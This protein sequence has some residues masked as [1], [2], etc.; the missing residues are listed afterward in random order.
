MH[1]DNRVPEVADCSPQRPN[2]SLEARV[3]GLVSGIP[4]KLIKVDRE[5]LQHVEFVCRL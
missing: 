1:S 3:M 2:R 5:P 4:T